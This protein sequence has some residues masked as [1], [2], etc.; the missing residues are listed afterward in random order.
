M[1]PLRKISPSK[2]SLVSYYGKNFVEL[3]RMKSN[4]SIEYV[5][6]NIYKQYQSK[7][8]S[9]LTPGDVYNNYFKA[10][11][12]YSALSN[13]FKGLERGELN[14]IF[15]RQQIEETFTPEQI[16]RLEVDGSRICGNTK[17]NGI[18]VVDK[19]DDFYKAL[20]SQTIAL[21]NIYDILEIDQ[22]KAPIDFSE[23][24]VFDKY[25]PVGIILGYLIGLE[26]LIKLLGVKITKIENKDALTKDMFTIK[27][28]DGLYAFDKRHT[29]GTKILSGLNEYEK[30]LKNLNLRDLNHKDTYYI[31]F[32]DKKITSV[33]VKEIE[34]TNELFIDPI[35]E[36]IL[37][38]MGEPTTFS[39][40][41]VRA[42]EML[43]EYTYPDSQD[44][45][46]MRVRGY[47]RIAGFI[48]KEL[49]RS[50]KTFKNKNIN[51]R[52]KVD[53]GPYDIW[54][55]I[56]KDNSVKLVEDINPV[57]DL[58]ERDLVTYVG[59]GGRDKGAI[60]KEAR[61]FHTTDFGVISEATVDSSDVAVNT[62]LTANPNFVN[63]RGKVSPL[64]EVSTTAV[65]SASA[66]I[67]PFSVMD[68]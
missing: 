19:H 36:S 47:E 21:G 46:Q 59:E 4:S 67:A 22:A 56:L 33:Y 68:D 45:T 23:F 34:L 18:I 5:I 50:I 13:R 54:N 2:V 31:L 8:I 58:K 51:G 64:S 40:L 26:N 39:G 14:L 61:S 7:D 24:R 53:L 11:Y 43:D 32:E 1:L 10:P 20:G 28:K 35:T 16:S 44:F 38:D 6:K 9:S 48:Y 29:V 63:L 27:F 15:F 37:K 41:L 57:Q 49:T 55:A 52:S 30:T 62:Y 12:I 65:M 66:N 17:D 60:Q 25:I 42:T 3:S